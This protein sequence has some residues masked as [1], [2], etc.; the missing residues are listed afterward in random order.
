M[1]LKCD[2]FSVRCFVLA[3]DSIYSCT[4]VH[5]FFFACMNINVHE[6][7]NQCQFK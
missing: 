5:M 6:K 2:M 3:G 4:A 7:Y 1:R